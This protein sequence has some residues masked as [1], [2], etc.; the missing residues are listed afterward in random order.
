MLKWCGI[1]KATFF[2]EIYQYPFLAVFTINF[3]RFEDHLSRTR[4]N[5]G[6]RKGAIATE[7]GTFV[8]SKFAKKS[9]EIFPRVRS[10]FS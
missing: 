9:V 5:P 10:S 1:T 6:V 8:S 3:S 2:I 4:R 7:D